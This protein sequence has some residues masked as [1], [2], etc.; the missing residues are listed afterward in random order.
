M[1]DVTLV[2]VPLLVLPIVLLFRFIGCGLDAVG[3]LVLPVPK[4]RDYILSDP[5]SPERGPVKHPSVRPNRND[6]IA[7]WRLVDLEKV[8]VSGD[9]RT[10]AP[11]KDERGFQNGIYIKAATAPETPGPTSPGSE[12]SNG[13]FDFGQPSLI[14]SD[15]AQSCRLFKGGYV[16]VPYKD[17]LYPEQFTIEAWVHPKWG[18]NFDTDFE[19]TLFSA[20]GHYRRPFDASAA[21]AY[22]GFS[23]VADRHGRWQVR[24]PNVGDLIA[25]APFVVKLPTHLAVTVTKEGVK[26]RVR[27]FAG[28]KEWQSDLV[29]YSPPLGAPLLIGMASKQAD[30]T[31]PV[32]AHRPVISL[33]QEV[34]LHRKPLSAV[35]IENHV[36]IN[37]IA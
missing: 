30:P 18:G 9:I 7:Y 19:H 15:P 8:A 31:Q 13:T 34:V 35:E 2:L 33:I 14:L 4:Y 22:H 11:A 36:D 32:V 16:T 26:T 5:N 23:V 6:V 28:G 3:T 25:N 17:G 1:V 37:R 29:D 24:F 27:L 20:G 12:Y 21:A 10:D